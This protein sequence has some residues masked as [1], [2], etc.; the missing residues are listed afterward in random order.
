ML[1]DAEFGMLRL[2]A[3]G[4]YSFKVS[5]PLSYMKQVSGTSGLAETQGITGQ[6]KRLIVSG[7]TDLL[8]ELRIPALDLAANYDEIS[9]K[10]QQK[11]AAKFSEFGLTLA[12]FYVENISLPQ[13]VEA[14][15]DKRTAVNMFGDVQQYAQFQAADSIKDAA[16]N[17]GGLAGAGVGL[18]AGAAMGS[19][20]TQAFTQPQQPQQ[21]QRQGSVCPY[22]GAQTPAGAKFCPV[23]GKQAQPTGG[24][25]VKCGA[26]IAANAKFCPECGAPQAVETFCKNCG[27]KL[28][29]DAKFC[30]ECGNKVE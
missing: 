15:L 5:D 16:N 8:G 20:F 1:R 21:P 17:P 3:Y 11:L 2:R 10:A 24:K 23:C 9:E 29:S 27:A 6:L 4:I 14:M 28:E 7:L 12:S 26:A 30:P 19:V 25:C 13:E 18:G 22:C